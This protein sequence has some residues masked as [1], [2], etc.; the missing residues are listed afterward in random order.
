M[1]KFIFLLLVFL[2]SLTALAYT[3]LFTDV[4]VQIQRRAVQMGVSDIVPMDM[5]TLRAQRR[6]QEETEQQLDRRERNLIQFRNQMTDLLQ[7]IAEVAESQSE[8]ETDLQLVN[9]EEGQ[10]RSRSV[11]QRIDDHLTTIESRM[12]AN[13]RRV[14][15]L[16]SELANARAD[17]ANLRQT[18]GELERIIRAQNET[19]QKLRSR[20]NTLEAQLA[21]AEQE[22]QQLQE[23]LQE[24]E[25]EAK[26]LQKAYY[27]SKPTDQLRDLGIIE[28]KFLR[29]SQLGELRRKNFREIDV[30]TRR[31]YFDKRYDA[32]IFSDHNRKPSLYQIQDGVVVIKDPDAF[33]RVSRY[34]IIELQ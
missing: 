18:V 32:K 22:N 13:Q 27:I 23:G 31:I 10:R 7:D 6:K 20:A 16:R 5:K 11:R 25:E 28:K 15:S 17:V 29:P 33:W 9:A 2:I 24:M 1:K 12:A 34:L 21:E 4:G 3:L 19:L 14:R 8:V 30:S 26:K